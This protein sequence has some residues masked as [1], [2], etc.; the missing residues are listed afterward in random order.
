MTEAFPS[1]SYH[2][3]DGYKAK[4]EVYA[5]A[6]EVELLLNGKQIGKK[7]T[8]KD[9]V[10]S[11]DTVYQDGELTAVAYDKL[12]KEIKRTYL[13]TAEEDT[14]LSIIPEADSVKAE[15]LVYL[16]L[17][18]TD[19]NGIWK[20]MEKH[21]VQVAVEGGRLKGLGNACSYNPDGYQ[22]DYTNTYYG[23]ALA[24]VQADG[25]GLLRVMVKDE[26][27]EYVVVIPLAEAR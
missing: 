26:R 15:G 17:V 21:N 25:T 5:R 22:N 3:C 7:R 27:K 8:R 20:P 9:C 24:V 12:G 6:Y 1:W 23:R 18:Y 4:V 10:I 13:K 16:Q 2:G 14:V 11:F 19:V